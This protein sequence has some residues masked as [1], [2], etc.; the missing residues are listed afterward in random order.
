LRG[1]EVYLDFELRRSACNACGVKNEKLAFL[2]SNTKS[3]LRFAMQIRGLCRAMTIQDVARLMHLDWE[4]V[5]ELDKIY[6]REQLRQAGHPKPRVIGVDEIS[7][8]KGHSYRIFVSDLVARRAIWF[9]GAG[10]TE[11]DMDLFHAFLGTQNSRKIKLAVWT[12]GSRFAFRRNVT[13]QEPRSCSTGSTWSSILAMR[14]MSFAARSTSASRARIAASSKAN[15]MCCC[16]GGR[17]FDAAKPDGAPRELMDSSRILALVWKREIALDNG[18][19]GA[20]RWFLE[21]KLAD[22][23]RQNAN[24][25]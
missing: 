7:I 17:T 15:A 11:A 19:A 20:Y 13:R 1:H 6:M 24:V 9:G 12:C 3:T 10:R 18:V 25:A 2:S 5:K 8:K 21:N 16:R 4:A 14:W 23:P 22:T